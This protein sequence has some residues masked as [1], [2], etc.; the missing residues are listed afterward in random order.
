MK[1]A[2]LY[3]LS[4]LLLGCGQSLKD[5][6]SDCRRDALQMH[7]TSASQNSYI[8][9]NYVKSC[10]AAKGY[11]FSTLLYGCSRGDLYEEPACYT[12]WWKTS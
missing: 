8:L 12:R 5:D 11:S 6:V 4:L 7:Q 3:P 2:W 10:M 1:V 9:D